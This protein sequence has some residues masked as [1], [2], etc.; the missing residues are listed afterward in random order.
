MKNR[1]SISSK[2]TGLEG[3]FK[4][5]DNFEMNNLRGG[6]SPKGIPPIPPSGGDDYPIPLTTS[7]SIVSVISVSSQ[8]QIPV[9]VISAS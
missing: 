8:Q 3:Q 2:K 9:V 4:S 5:L 1:T 6:G 7:A